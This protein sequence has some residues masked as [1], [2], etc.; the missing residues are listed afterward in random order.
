MAVFGNSYDIICTLLLNCDEK[1]CTDRI[2]LR[3]ETSGRQDDSEEV[4]KKRFNTFHNESMPIID[5]LK[6]ICSIV[7][8]DSITDKDLV[9]EEVCKKMDPLLL[10]KL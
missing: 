6:K 3:G 8:V 5:E 2:R 7:E 9:F 4:I 10:N 1:T